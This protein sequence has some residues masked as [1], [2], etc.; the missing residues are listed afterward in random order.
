[1]TFTRITVDPT[2]MA[3]VPIVRGLRIPVATIVAM[4]ADGMTTEE[5]LRDLPDLEPDDISESLHFAAEGLRE[6]HLPLQPSA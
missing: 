4:V 2:V 6:R 1:M 3:G 5:I